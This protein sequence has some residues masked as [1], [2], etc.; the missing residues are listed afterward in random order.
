[1]I[2]ISLSC[3]D[4]GEDMSGGRKESVRDI[5]LV[6]GGHRF[7]KFSVR[8]RC[9]TFMDESHHPHHQVSRHVIITESTGI[10]VKIMAQ[11]QGTVV[12][13]LHE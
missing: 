7:R 4:I 5:L 10:G 1:M 8:T 13:L 12:V 11:G 2:R 6:Q 3:P 9:S